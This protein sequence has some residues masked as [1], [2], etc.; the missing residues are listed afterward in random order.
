MKHK[1]FIKYITVLMCIMCI[2]NVSILPVQAGASKIVVDKKSFKG[3]LDTSLWNDINGDV[4]VENNTLIFP[5]KSTKSTG[6][7]STVN[8]KISSYHDYLVRA[9]V[10]MQFLQLPANEKFV[11]AFGLGSIEASMGEAGNVEVQF[12]KNK[13]LEVAVV[14]YSDAEEPI[15]VLKGMSCG[16]AQNVKVE[17]AITTKDVLIL[18]VNG[19]KICEKELQVTGE[20]RVG[21]LQTG[22]C[23]VTIRDLKIET[24]E[25]DRPENCDVYE[26][27]EQGAININ[28]LTSRMVYPNM[29]Y[30]PSAVFIDKMEDN[31]VFRFKNCAMSY[32]G[33]MYQYSNFEMTFDVVYLQREHEMDEEGNIVTAKN[34]NFAVSF[35]DEMQD[36]STYGYLTST[37]LIVFEPG[38]TVSSLNTDNMAS[39]AK[40]GYPYY[41]ANCNRKFSVRVSVIDAVV[42]VSMKWLEEDKYTKILEYQVSDKTPTGY[43]HLWT[44]GE[45]ANFAIDSLRIVNKDQDP[46]TVEA[47]YQSSL[48]TAPEDYQ[49]EPLKHVYKENEARETFNPYIIILPLAGLCVLAVVIALVT[50]KRTGCREDGEAHEKKQME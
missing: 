43:V 42:S 16:N 10:D 22:S 17:A 7:I 49:Y 20:G 45:V 3:K 32:I 18:K 39:A 4:T 27:F 8:A 36:Y 6:L 21:F 5:K 29:T 19:K 34:G 23:A 35:G 12:T 2:A 50:N 48:V 1:G 15:T 25:Y 47:E 11:L 40:K 13:G 26:D 30:A 33:T 24:Y 9:T 31:Q 38:S 41:E 44:T 46:N 28:A 37:D 14:T